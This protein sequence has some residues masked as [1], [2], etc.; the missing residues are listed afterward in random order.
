MK[1]I[2]V[3]VMGV[4]KGSTMVEYCMESDN[5][6]IVAICDKWEEYFIKNM[7]PHLEKQGLNPTFYTS[8]DEFIK[9]D[10]DAVVLANYA[11]QHAPFAIRCLKAGLHVLSEVVP[12]QTMAE[13]VE[14]VETVEKTGKIYAFA[15]NYCYLPGPR[16]MKKLYKEGAI[17]EFEYGEGEYMHNCEPLW[18]MVTQG[19]ESHW[20]NHM[21]ATF[22]CTHSIGP[23][24]HITGL[25]PIKVV[26][27]EL[28]FN[29]RMAR[30]GAK[31]GHTGI[32]MITLENGAVIKS[33][34]G[35]GCSRDSVWYSVYGTNGRLET[36]REDADNGAE[37]RIFCNYDG[38]NKET[39][40]G[41]ATYMP[42]SASG[43][44]G[45]SDFYTMYNFIEKIRGNLDA[46]IV[47]IYE[48]LD[49][50]LPGMFAYRSI[51]NDNRPF[52]I[53]DLRQKAVRNLYR[54][55]TFCTDPN[56]AGEQLVPS[57]SKGNPEIDWKI[58][59]RQRGEPID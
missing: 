27:F 29:D 42:E 54:Y 18:G 33:I 39:G 31:S 21:Y 56:V 5:A 50:F 32:E 7:K 58:Y 15:E 9:H 20:R 17:G 38:A 51:L 10:M 49:M 45:G 3:G 26:G 34:H 43:G 12:V 4:Q 46:D 53:P 11:T 13:A 41:Y 2:R 40:E 36:S 1:K 37:G 28:P 57:Y 23:I 30:M 52:N 48:A 16:E 19:N 25:R 14:L 24:L 8:F 55:D 22:Y 35:V 6:E 47:D 44:H 59:A